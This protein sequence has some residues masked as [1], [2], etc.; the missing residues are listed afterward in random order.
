MFGIR[1]DILADLP[2]AM[3]T[4]ESERIDRWILF[5]SNQG[6]DDHVMGRWRELL[7]ARTYSIK[8]RIVSTPRTIAGGHTLITMLPDRS[9][10]ELDLAAYE[11]SKSFR[12]VVRRLRPGDVVRAVGE[13]RAVPRTLN[14]E[15][16]EVL[17][18]ASTKVKTANPT[19]SRC[20]K[21]MQSMGRNGGYRC[22]VCGGKQ[23]ESAATTESEVRKLVQGWYEPPVSARRHLAKPLKRTPSCVASS[24]VDG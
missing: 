21:S 19:C 7:P 2:P 22:R 1:G 20:K 15:K 5:L 16:I 10:Q 23:P 8:G 17:E 11:P 6:T 9:R 4:I 12:E 24:L 13:L 14:L 3:G 18:L